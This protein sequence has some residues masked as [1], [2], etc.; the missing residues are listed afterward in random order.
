MRWDFHSISQQ[1][2]VLV[3]FHRKSMCATL[4]GSP[5][6]NAEASGAAAFAPGTMWQWREVRREHATHRATNSAVYAI[7][8]ETVL[9][10]ATL[11]GSPMENAEASGAAAFAPGTVGI[12]P[13]LSISNK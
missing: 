1:E 9:M 13:L 3:D 2:S 11:K 6:E 5:M 8:R 7:V 10:C 4:K 12:K